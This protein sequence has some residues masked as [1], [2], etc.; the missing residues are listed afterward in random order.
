MRSTV[1][2]AVQ[3]SVETTYLLLLFCKDR[4]KVLQIALQPKPSTSS[5][6]SFSC[7]GSSGF[8][9]LI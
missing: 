1:S 9:S 5:H 8:M 7:C 2:E 4:D 6:Q 3:S